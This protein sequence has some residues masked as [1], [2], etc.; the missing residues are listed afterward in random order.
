MATTE[1]KHKPETQYRVTMLIDGSKVES[2]AQLTKEK[3]GGVAVERVEKI[4]P[5][6]PG[7]WSQAVYGEEKIEKYQGKPNPDAWVNADGRRIERHKIILPGQEKKAF[8]DRE[9]GKVFRTYDQ[10]G[11][12]D[13]ADS[14]DKAR[15]M[16]RSV[17][18]TTEMLEKADLIAKIIAKE[19][20]YDPTIMDIAKEYLATRR[21]AVDTEPE[22]DGDKRRKPQYDVNLRIEGSTKDAVITIAKSAFGD[23]LKSVELVEYGYSRAVDL[24]RA[25]SRVKEAVESVGELRSGLEEWKEG[26]PEQFQGG[27]KEEELDSAISALEEIENA[28]DGIGWDVEFPGMF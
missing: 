19:E 11:F 8:K 25:E 6:V 3:V 14:L 12:I 17:S 13:Q 4:E 20:S 2:V 27:Y 22:R 16:L 18:T 15:K 1:T 26:M 10:F 24:G 21:I 5:F 9:W 28:L 23:K 7:E